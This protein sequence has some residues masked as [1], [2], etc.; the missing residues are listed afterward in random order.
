MSY[1]KSTSKNKKSSKFLIS[2]ICLILA[3]IMLF[4]GSSFTYAKYLS[5]TSSSESF[6]FY[7]YTLNNS[8]NDLIY[9]RYGG[10]RLMLSQESVMLCLDNDSDYGYDIEIETILRWD[11]ALLSESEAIYV[12]VYVLDE[13]G[14]ST[15]VGTKKL[16]YYTPWYG[17]YYYYCGDNSGGTPNKFVV[18]NA[19]AALIAS[20]NYENIILQYL[21]KNIDNS[22]S[23][24][25]YADVYNN[26][27]LINLL[28]YAVQH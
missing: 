23:I 11:G 28:A 22:Y 3:S 20:G 8:N 7:N 6:Y 15:L 14:L 25:N 24:Y 5:L 16:N 9:S 21:Q 18:N 17:S 4:L 10:N 2:L 19:G 26:T 1:V 12:G 27:T 13:N